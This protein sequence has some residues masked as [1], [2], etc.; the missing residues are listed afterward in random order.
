[1][2]EQSICSKCHSN[3]RASDY[4]CFN[5]G[6]NLHPAPLSTTPITQFSI[7]IGSLLLPPMGLIWGFRYLRQKSAAAKI[8]GIVSIGLTIIILVVITQL[9]INLIN[10]V[11]TQVNKQMENIQQF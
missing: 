6:N 7:Y 4:Y 1:M 8:V 10:T 9:S 3:I 5:C 11:N 2:D